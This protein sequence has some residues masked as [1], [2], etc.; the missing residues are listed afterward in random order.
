MLEHDFNA[1]DSILV[2]RPKAPLEK[3]DFTALAAAID[4]QIE[5]TGAL[6]GVIID[7]PTFPGWDDFGALVSHLRFIREHQKHIRKVA[8]VTDSMAGNV[9]EHLASHFVSA[10]IKHFGAG[11]IGAARQWISGD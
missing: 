6:A 8:I 4:P 5:S 1:A 7:A 2:V 11:Q 9:A 10:Q 3:T